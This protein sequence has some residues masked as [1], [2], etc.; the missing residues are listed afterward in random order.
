MEEDEKYLTRR[1]PRL[2]GPVSLHYCKSGG[3]E[4]APCWKIIDCWWEIFDVV[5]YLQ[6]TLSADQYRRLTG[7]RPKAKVTHIL[8]V[9]QQIKDARSEES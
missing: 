2:G 5:R 8:E 4:K 3:P 1:C 6:E 9:V 7:A